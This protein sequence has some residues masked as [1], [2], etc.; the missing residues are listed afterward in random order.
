MNT[1]ASSL[2]YL[3]SKYMNQCSIQDKDQ[4]IK[5]LS[6]WDTIPSNIRKAS[7]EVKKTRQQY[8]QPV[9]NLEELEKII[10]KNLNYIGILTEQTSSSIDKLS[11]RV[12]KVSQQPNCLGGPRAITWNL[13]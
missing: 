11:E 8:S 6:L 4:D 12:I 9:E 3:Y 10:K 1:E 13:M 5:V 2:P 7:L